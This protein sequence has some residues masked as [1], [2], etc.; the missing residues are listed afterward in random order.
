[1][2]LII[3]LLFS[4]LLSGIVYGYICRIGKRKLLKDYEKDYDKLHLYVHYGSKKNKAETEKMFDDIYKYSC[5]NK[6]KLEVLYNEFKNKINENNR[7]K[8][9]SKTG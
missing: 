8:N 3:M 6:E 5:R 4:I 1:M 9:N 2:K 7:A